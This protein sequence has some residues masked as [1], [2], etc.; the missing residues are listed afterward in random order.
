MCNRAR[1]SPLTMR[2]PR[3]STLLPVVI[4]VACAVV[5]SCGDSTAP[6]DR[7]RM[8]ILERPR[9]TDGDTVDTELD[10]EL[11]L[12]LRDS[13]GRPDPDAGVG[14]HGV[15]PAGVPFFTPVLRLRDASDPESAWRDIGGYA[16]A[17]A[18]GVVR[19]KV[20]LGQVAGE[21]L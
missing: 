13:T 5:I 14:L 18:Q 19:V 16:S 6:G 7:A 10:G 15:A 4:A 21:I 9:S 3:P 2:C 1:L 8:Q 12:L 17:D 20:A 11:V